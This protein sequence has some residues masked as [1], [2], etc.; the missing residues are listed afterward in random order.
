M[1][2]SSLSPREK[3]TK[4]RIEMQYKFPA[5]SYLLMQLKLEKSEELEKEGHTTFLKPDGTL[6]YNEKWVEETEDSMELASHVLHP[7]LHMGLQHYARKGARDEKTWDRAIDIVTDNILAKEKMPR[8][9]NEQG[10]KKLSA[11]E[12]YQEIYREPDENDD[13]DGD[14]DGDNN[15]DGNGGGGPQKDKHSHDQQPTV[16]QQQD[17]EDKMRQA[18]EFAM[19]QGSNPGI[20]GEM[21]SELFDSEVH[22]VAKLW[23]FITNVIVSDYDWSKPSRKLAAVQK[24]TTKKIFLPSTKKEDVELAIVVDTSGSVPDEDLNRFRSEVSAIFH[25]FANISMTVIYHTVDVEEVTT[26]KNNSDIK[27]FVSKE[28]YWGGTCH[29]SSF[30]YIEENLPNVSAVVCFTDGYTTTPEHFHKP[31]LW[32][33]TKNS[34]DGAIKFGTI[35]HYMRD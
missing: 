7:V 4:M 29:K 3:L 31:T 17:W 34:S 32:V 20:L 12:V 1:S 24:T 22:W 5:Y 26:L 8:V 2:L 33:L 15:G 30:K 13:G 10:Y 16:E 6:L 19:G 21:V 11:E 25:Q 18:C 27:E 35:S 28:R 14:G 23:A 9:S